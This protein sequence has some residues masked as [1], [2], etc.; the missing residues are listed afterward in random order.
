[1]VEKNELLERKL[2]EKKANVLIL[3]FIINEVVSASR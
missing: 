1:M 2:D 3:A